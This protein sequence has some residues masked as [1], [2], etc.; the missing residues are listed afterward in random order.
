MGVRNGEGNLGFSISFA[1][2]SL[3]DEDLP[4]ETLLSLDVKFQLGLGLQIFCAGLMM[5]I[6]KPSG[7]TSFWNPSA[8]I[9]QYIF[10]YS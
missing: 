2:F 3:E 5:K 9:N 4:P 6:H 1:P 7:N 8:G 10:F